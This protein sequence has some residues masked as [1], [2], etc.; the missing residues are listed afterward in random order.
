MRTKHVSIFFWLSQFTF[1]FTIKHVHLTAGIHFEETEETTTI[2]NTDNF[3]QAMNSTSSE[4]LIDSLGTIILI[5]A[6]M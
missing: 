2:V 3:A 6:R 1:P 5:F 4:I